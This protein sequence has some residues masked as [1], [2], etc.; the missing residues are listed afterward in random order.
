MKAS[1]DTTV[2][3]ATATVEAAFEPIPS[4]FDTSVINLEYRVTTALVEFDKRFN[5]LHGSSYGHI[6]KTTLPAMTRCINALEARLFHSQ[7]PPA[8]KVDPSD[9]NALNANDN[10]DIAPDAGANDK[11]DN[12]LD[13]NDDAKMDATTRSRD[14]S[15]SAR[16]RGGVNP[17]TAG[18]PHASYGG[19]TG[20]GLTRGPVTPDPYRPSTMSHR[21]H[22][23]LRQTTIPELLHHGARSAPRLTTY[24]AH[25]TAS[26][27]RF[28]VVVGGYCVPMT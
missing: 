1:L 10:D 22:P 16:T 25:D 17:I 12:G 20:R 3:L 4:S 18:P 15:A 27:W 7:P 11:H 5:A 28:Q 26:D 19:G 6:T 14:A 9:G 2:A 8:D 23:S 21:D 24:T 13:V